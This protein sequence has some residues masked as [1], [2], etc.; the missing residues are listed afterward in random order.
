MNASLRANRSGVLRVPAKQRTADEKPPDRSLC[1]PAYPYGCA[2]NALVYRQG[3]HGPG[4]E[5]IEVPA[6]RLAGDA[7]EAQRIHRQ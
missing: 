1:S 7:L 2:V 6:R 5:R 4:D 3:P